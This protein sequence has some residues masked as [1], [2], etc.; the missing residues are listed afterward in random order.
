MSR[1]ISPPWF[2]LLLL[3]HLLS[4]VTC[5]PKAE[6]PSSPTT[7]IT[8]TTAAPSISTTTTRA[9]EQ[10][11]EKEEE[12]EEELPRGTQDPLRWVWLDGASL[13]LQWPAR[14]SLSINGVVTAYRLALTHPQEPRPFATTTMYNADTLRHQF[15]GLRSNV[16]YDGQL[17]ALVGPHHWPYTLLNF[18]V[19]SPTLHTGLG[20]GQRA[21]PVRPRS[22]TGDLQ[23]ITVSATLRWSPTPFLRGHAA[24]E[25]VRPAGYRLRVWDPKQLV[26]E[27]VTDAATHGQGCE[28]AVGGLT[29]DSV[30]KA[31]LDAVMPE[32]EQGTSLTFTLDAG[33]LHVA[34]G[35]LTTDGVSECYSGLQVR[36]PGSERCVSPYWICDDAADCPDGADEVGCDATPCDGFRCWDDV[37]IPWAWRCDGRVDCKEGKDEYGCPPCDQGDLRCPWGGEC[38][39]QNATCDGVAHCKDGWDESAVL[40]GS[41]TCGAGELQCLGGS[42]CVPHQWLCDGVPDCPAGEDEDSA[43]CSAFT[44]FRDSAVLTNA[45][46]ESTTCESR[47]PPKR[48]NCTEAEFRCDARSCIEREYVCDG[49]RDCHNGRD[50]LPQSC[51]LAPTLATTTRKFRFDSEEDFNDAEEGVTSD[52]N[53]A[54]CSEREGE[55][56]GSVGTQ[57]RGNEGGRELTTTTEISHTHTQESS[58]TETPEQPVLDPINVIDNR[59]PDIRTTPSSTTTSTSA[60]PEDPI[61]RIIEANMTDMGINEIDMRVLENADEVVGD[62]GNK[63]LHDV[64][65]SVEV[66]LEEEEEEEEEEVNGEGE[67]KEKEEEKLSPSQSET[68]LNLSSSEEYD[69][70]DL[71]LEVDRLSPIDSGNTTNPVTQG[72][73]GSRQGMNITTPRVHDE[74]AEEEVNDGEP[75][76]EENANKE[77][78]TF[79]LSSPTNEQNTTTDEEQKDVSTEG[80]AGDLEKDDDSTV[81]LVSDSP[82]T[83][84][85]K[86]TTVTEA[87][88]NLPLLPSGND[89]LPSPFSTSTSDSLHDTTTTTFRIPTSDVISTTPPTSTSHS[90]LTTPSSEV[91]KSMEE[92]TVLHPGVGNA[93]LITESST[94]GEPQHPDRTALETTTE[95]LILTPTTIPTNTYAPDSITTTT[96][97]ATTTTSTTGPETSPSAAPAPTDRTEETTTTATTDKP[98]TP[99]APTPSPT[100]T[101]F[102]TEPP[103][104]EAKHMNRTILI[105]IR[106]GLNESEVP[107]YIIHGADGSTYPYEI[108]SIVRE[109]IDEKQEKE[110]E[111]RMSVIEEEEEM[112]NEI[113]GDRSHQFLQGI[114]ISSASRLSSPSTYF[115]LLLSFLSTHFFAVK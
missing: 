100:N 73:G 57:A 40:C 2:L 8:T 67:V 115:F 59:L 78:G 12:E 84:P 74:V 26:A 13:S 50:E 76:A 102:A 107:E 37:C 64:T 95:S 19:T 38:L 17:V 65:V 87:T 68:S 6:T 104:Q 81:L 61:I 28:A 33:A 35:G 3:L 45:T 29:L 10:R 96:T 112:T 31:T 1:L 60:S 111:D 72:E 51:S 114:H 34:G 90:D 55:F 108:V 18:T 109:E 92:G 110:N 11:Q 48:V 93:S 70:E 75:V 54:E 77:N 30:Y 85:G 105:A 42:R 62:E 4:P 15:E 22:S 36:C 103:T 27:V 94:P 82:V 71:P 58:T 47:P 39:P 89:T 21:H 16:S 66:F 56:C 20:L 88:V 106:A 43:F 44:A 99:S 97:S 86:E 9:R 53:E 79:T 14:F 25:V 7:T 83:V 52:E 63:T 49:V 69:N 46:S 23:D 80:D 32:E 113:R 41:V 91:R 101:T 5:M 98:T 24:G